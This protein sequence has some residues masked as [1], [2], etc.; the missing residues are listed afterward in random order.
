MADSLSHQDQT[1]GS[2]WA[3]TQEMVSDLQ[4]RWPVMIDLFTTALNYHLPVYFSLLNTLMAAGT[5]A[6]LQSYAFPPFSLIRQVLSKL[7]CSRGTLLTLIAPLWPQKEWYTIQIFCVC[8]WLLLSPCFH[9]PICSDSPMSI[10]CTKSSPCYSFMR[11]DCRALCETYRSF[12]Q[13]RPSALRVA[14]F[15]RVSC[16]SIVGRVT[17]AGLQIGAILLSPCY[18]ALF[19]S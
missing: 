6:F 14:V 5:D 15:P 17:V 11:G 7:Q 4:R 2:E 8:R 9:V 1:N 12:S 16:T 3:L 19:I 10:V 13:G 18:R